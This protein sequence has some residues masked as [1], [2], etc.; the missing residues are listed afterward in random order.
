[1]VEA[2]RWLEEFGARH[3][4]LHR[5][6][7]YWLSIPVLILGTVGLLWSL[8]VPQE[9]REISPALNWG[10]ALL[11]ATVVYYFILSMPLAFGMLPF[12]VGIA[13]FNFW[14]QWSPYSGLYASLGLVA[15]GIVGLVATHLGNGGARAVV[16]DLQHMMIAP[17]WLLSRLY[18]KIGIPH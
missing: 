16:N 13:G 12:V 1:M 15:G 14:L 3:R 9:F 6:P 7:V 2:D 10:T 4:R 5:L 8:P 18:H 17:V 11:L